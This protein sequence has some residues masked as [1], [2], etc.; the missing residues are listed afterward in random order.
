[1]RKIVFGYHTGYYGMDSHEVVEFPDDVTDLELDDYAWEGAVQYAESYGIHPPSDEDFDED[2][3][4][5]ENEDSPCYSGENIEG[6]WED[7]DPEKHD[8]LVL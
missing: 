2:G 1:M 4:E 5:I 6:W 7:Y 3:F 8:G